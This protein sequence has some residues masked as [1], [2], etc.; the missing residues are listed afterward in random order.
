[1]FDISSLVSG[2]ILDYTG[3]LNVVPWAVGKVGAAA[4]ATRETA[5]S[6]VST[7]TSIA[8]TTVRATGNSYLQFILF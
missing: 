8:A 2:G 7:T 3:V 1:L 5:S 4:T 6:I